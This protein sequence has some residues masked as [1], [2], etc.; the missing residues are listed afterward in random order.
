MTSAAVGILGGP[1]LVSYLPILEGTNP[2]KDLITSSIGKIENVLF[3]YCWQLFRY[4]VCRR[5]VDFY[6]SNQ[7]YSTPFC[8][9]SRRPQFLTRS[10]RIY[11]PAHAPDFKLLISQDLV[12]FSFFIFISAFN[13]KM[14]GQ[15]F[16][17][18][19]GEGL[20]S[21]LGK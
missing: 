18:P 10:A 4:C 12:F 19:V 5:R 14:R 9:R 15:I 17:P 7:F 13:R 3:F 2:V 1:E 11:I 20:W 16:F 8:M 6:R 21:Y